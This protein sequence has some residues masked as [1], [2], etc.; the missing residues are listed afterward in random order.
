MLFSV[1]RFVVPNVSKEQTSVTVKD[2]GV[3]QTFYDCIF[4]DMEGIFL[5]NIRNQ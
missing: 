1:R 2:Q 4:E 5:Q 3:Q